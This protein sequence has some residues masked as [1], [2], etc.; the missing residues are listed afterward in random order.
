MKDSLC[1]SNSVSVS[2]F[3]SLRF[4]T[5]MHTHILTLTRNLYHCFQSVLRKNNFKKIINRLHHHTGMLHVIFSWS[6]ENNNYLHIFIV[7]N[8]AS[9]NRE[10]LKYLRGCINNIHKTKHFILQIW[11]FM[12]FSFCERW[13]T[14]SWIILRKI[15]YNEMKDIHLP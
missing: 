1:I 13:W 2:L 10:D 5:H 14:E 4:Y 9:K 12:E 7:L 8:A 3:L 15:G 11:V 6:V